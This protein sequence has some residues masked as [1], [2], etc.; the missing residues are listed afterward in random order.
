MSAAGGG[1]IFVSYRREESSHIA[2]RLADHLVNRFGA[3]Q[4]FIDVE[5]IEPGV[6]FA[7]AI[8]LAVD[9]C[10]VLV[11]VIGPGWLV[12]ADERGGRRLDDP[13]DL[14]RLEIGAALARGVRVIPVLV[15]ASVMPRPED[16]PDSLAGLARR[17]ALRIR[18]ESF[19]N[20]AGRLITAIEGVLASAAGA[21][22]ARPPED[23]PGVTV[24]EGPRAGRNDTARAARLL[25]DAER[26]ANSITK[27]DAKA[28]ALSN[29]AEAVAVTDPDRAEGIAKSITSEHV[30]VLALSGIAKALAQ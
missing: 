25:D 5:A 30:K 15:E 21:E 18:H 12:A 9:A 8:S 13:D 10:A 28:Y 1:G 20:D 14:V 16:L 19:R 29:M 24:T 27:E 26:I 3:A 6:D 22:A 11:A 23:V 7:E 17:N 4:V 2:G